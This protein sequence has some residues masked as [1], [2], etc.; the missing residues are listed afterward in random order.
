MSW[1][2]WGQYK[3]LGN[4]DNFVWHFLLMFIILFLLL[5]YCYS[6]SLPRQDVMI[7]GGVVGQKIVGPIL[8]FLLDIFIGISNFPTINIL[9]AQPAPPLAFHK[10]AAEDAHKGKIY[11]A[12]LNL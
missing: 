8:S 3:G 5:V 6:T 4:Q 2:G 11:P 10:L 9:H 1:V 7:L 12:E